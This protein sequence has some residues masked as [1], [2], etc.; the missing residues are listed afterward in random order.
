MVLVELITVVDKLEQIVLYCLTFDS[1]NGFE[2][3][4]K[5]ATI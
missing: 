1:F 3:V 2:Q 4:F 5:L